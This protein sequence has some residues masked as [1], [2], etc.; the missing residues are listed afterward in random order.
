MTAHLVLAL[1]ETEPQILDEE[2][3]FSERADTTPGSTADLRKGERLPVREL[4]YGL[5]LPSGNDAAIALAEHFGPRCGDKDAK[6]ATSDPVEKF[7]ARMNQH[8]RQ[9]EMSDTHYAN[10]HGLP[11]DQHVSSARDLLRLACVAAKSPL[12][13]TYVSTRQHGCQVT[14]ANGSRRNV[15]WKNT[16]QLL[17]IEG[18]GGIKTGTTTAAGACLVAQG[19]H[20]NDPLMVVVLGATSSD[21]R[22]ADTRNL[23]RWA[24]QQRGHRD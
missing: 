24:W 18:Y 11:D 4:L 21:G 13:Q 15:L 10:P 12:F 20:A 7:V 19:Q 16:N 22:Y 5:M 6:S 1:A 8:A 2:L 23:F 9:L 3:V 14:G 17:E